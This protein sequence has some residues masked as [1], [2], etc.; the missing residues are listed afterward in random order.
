LTLILPGD[1]DKKIEKTNSKKEMKKMEEN[2]R[3]K[4]GMKP[5]TVVIASGNDIET[6]ILTSQDE[7]MNFVKDNLDDDGF[8]ESGV[9]RNKDG[10]QFIMMRGNAIKPRVRTTT[11]ISYR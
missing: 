7:L 3:K 6:V 4:H 10:W 5:V 8:D 9:A 2:G 11:K 1:N